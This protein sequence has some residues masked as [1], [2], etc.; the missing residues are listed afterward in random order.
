MV[1][2]SV[3]AE[4][5]RDGSAALSLEGGCSGYILSTQC[6]GSRTLSTL[7][8]EWMMLGLSG[9]LVLGVDTGLEEILIA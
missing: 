9:V 5:A 2:L 8:F 4:A 3:S 7:E 1:V 6:A